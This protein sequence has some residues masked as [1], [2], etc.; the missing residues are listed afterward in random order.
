M[1]FNS[2]IKANTN[3]N[4]FASSNLNGKLNYLKPVNNSYEANGNLNQIS[5]KDHSHHQNNGFKAFD[6]N[7]QFKAACDAIQNLPKNGP[8]QPS[9]EI[10]LKFYGY[11][12]QATE[13]KCKKSRPSMFNVVERAKWDAWYSVA[14]LTKTEAMQGY[15]NEIKNIIETMPHDKYVQKLTETLEPYEYITEPSEIQNGHDNNNKGSVHSESS[16]TEV[17]VA[18]KMQIKLNVNRKKTNQ[19]NNPTVNG[20][21]KKAVVEE[22]LTLRLPS[23]LNG[24]STCWNEWA[25]KNPKKSTDFL[26]VNKNNESMNFIPLSNANDTFKKASAGNSVADSSPSNEETKNTTNSYVSDDDEDFCD[27]SDSLQPAT[28]YEQNTSVNNNG[29]CVNN[30]PTKPPN[31]SEYSN[32]VTFIIDKYGGETT[33][34][35]AHS[36]F[37]NSGAAGNFASGQSQYRNS[38]PGS[39]LSFSNRSIGNAGGGGGGGYPP[40][41]NFQLQNLSQETNRQILL[42]LLRLQQDTNNVIT[43]LSYLE[44][45]VLSLQNNLQMNRI[46]SSIKLNNPSNNNNETHN[47][48]QA[49]SKASAF[50]QLN[51]NSTAVD[52]SGTFGLLFQ[53]LKSVDWK[54]VAIAFVWP[55]IIRL[56]FYILR[57]VRLAMKFRKLVKK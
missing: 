15:V 48:T 30:E 56:A 8:Y 24:R 32:E 53:F 1:A 37:Q 14:N 41:E 22:L 55:F 26:N 20:E 2:P 11:F 46:E 33:S 9:N 36:N 25:E 17:L 23:S 6:L 13:G 16:D 31:L 42:I 10:L 29:S 54:T 45:T 50:S 7:D 12:K 43:R 47:N 34:S 38:R 57:K 52:S 35:Q 28:E 4:L 49:S 27:T 5:V 3:L 18:D 21:A 44:A 40:N 39:S 19:N 51:T